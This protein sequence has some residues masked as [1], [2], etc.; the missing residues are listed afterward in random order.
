MAPG[1]STWKGL[2]V[3]LYGESQIHQVTAGNDI[4]TLTAITGATGDFL[5]CETAGGGEVF[6]VGATGALAI[7]GTVTL[8]NSSD[9]M[10]RDR[11]L[12]LGSG[13]V[14]TAPTTGMIKGDMFLQWVT[15]NTAGLGMCLSTATQAVKWCRVFN[16]GT[17]GGDLG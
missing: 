9:I 3:P 7:N 17:A 13:A 16:A 5:V 6:V 14:T 11:Y 10:L 8:T 15:V 2:A 4:L 12:N 1:D